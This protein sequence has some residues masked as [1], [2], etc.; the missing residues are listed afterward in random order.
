MKPGGSYSIED[1]QHALPEF[2]AKDT[3]NILE[4]LGV[5]IKVG[6]LITF[7]DKNDDLLL[8]NFATAEL[9]RLKR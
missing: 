7:E 1:F 5:C 4:A 9:K 8:R 3:I 2:D 6:L